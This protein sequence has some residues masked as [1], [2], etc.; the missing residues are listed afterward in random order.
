MLVPVF[1]PRV[2][3]IV[4]IV[5][6]VVLVPIPVLSVATVVNRVT[7]VSL[8]PELALRVAIIVVL[9]VTIVI[10]TIRA[11]AIVPVLTVSLIIIVL[12]IVIIMHIYN[13][14][15]KG[16]CLRN[17]ACLRTIVWTA[18]TNALLNI[19]VS[20]AQ[21][22]IVMIMMVAQVIKTLFI[23]PSIA[24][25]RMRRFASE[26]FIAC[27]VRKNDDT[28]LCIHVIVNQITKLIILSLSKFSVDNTIV[29]FMSR[30]K[31]TMIRDVR[32]HGKVIAE[33]GGKR[34]A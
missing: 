28:I 5:V 23:V 13:I 31:N 34:R 22:V 33:A 25:I 30:N 12:C 20:G 3:V 11:V 6:A 4:V 1:M 19:L 15:R 24:V 17:K 7:S 29:S 18:A 2:V 8:V 10:S 32:G 21:I 16:L 9:F 27:I 26:S 14:Q